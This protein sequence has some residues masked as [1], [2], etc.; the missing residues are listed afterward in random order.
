MHSFFFAFSAFHSAAFQVPFSVSSPAA[1]LARMTCPLLLVVFFLPSVRSQNV[2]GP[3]QPKL[4]MQRQGERH[5]CSKSEV[6]CHAGSC[7]IHR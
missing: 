3:A 6:V 7:G 4:L 5:S 2:D 1:L